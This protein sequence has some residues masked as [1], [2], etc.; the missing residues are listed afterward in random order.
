MR[1][2]KKL[3]AV[4]TV[5][6]MVWMVAGNVLAALSE[7]QIQAILGLLR[8]FGA[9]QTTISNVESAL[10]GRPTPPAPPT[11]PSVCVGITFTRDLRIGMSGD[12]VKCLQALL[13]VTP[14]T[15]Y[16]GPLTAEAVKRFQE[17]YASE[18]LTPLGLT[19]GTG[20]V[21]ARTRAKLNELLTPPTPPAPPPEQPPPEQPPAPP[22]VEGVLSASLEPTPANV[23]LNAG[24]QNKAVMAFK[25]TA[26]A[27]PIKIERVD[28]SFLGVKPWRCF[29]YVSLYD[30]ENPIKGLNITKDV[31]LDAGAGVYYVR[32]TGL[33]FTVPVGSSGKVVT[34]R[35]SAVSSYPQDCPANTSVTISISPTGIRGVDSAGLQQYAGN[36][37][38]I[39]KL[40]SAISGNL[41][42]SLA[43]DTPKE[44]LAI[45]SSSAD[46]T[47]IELLRFNVKWEML[48]GKVTEV[49]V[50]LT[51]DTN[52]TKVQALNL[53]DGTTLLGTVGVGS[54]N[55]SFDATF[56]GLA[57]SLAKDSSKTLSVKAVV[58]KDFTEGKYLK[59]TL[60]KVSGEDENE[61]PDSAEDNR[62]GNKIYIYKVAPVI[63]DISVNAEPKDMNATPGAETIVAKISFKVTAKGG[64]IWINANETNLE[65]IAETTLS[66]VNPEGVS[67]V[68][69]SS[70]ASKGNWGYRVPQDQTVTF[71][72]DATHDPSA[73][74]A[75]Y[76]RVRITQLE[77]N[78][79]DNGNGGHKF[80]E[81]WAIGELKTGYVYLTQD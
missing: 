22:P 6:S 74:A 53:Y 50:N 8:S 31:V 58:E 48:G 29:S 5:A 62:E 49:K 47:E 81:E 78:T 24:E 21:G 35:L 52:L 79:A 67:A 69:L 3:V 41:V 59:A 77:W 20:Y 71:T 68:V 61:I 40:G 28:L 51:S 39:F 11:V 75:G 60:D 73:N 32:L 15:G 43:S 26:L 16:F 7:E 13:E 56:S 9:D 37:Q 25:L 36:V 65:V 23:T 19:S 45:I 1:I 76:W 63:S 72:V 33:D 66:G 38:R 42:S 70:N 64:D 14:Q 54:N 34:V 55:T 18:I 10:R 46:T 17:K 44:G 4:A 2:L 27:S 80:N 57:I 30:G 12:D